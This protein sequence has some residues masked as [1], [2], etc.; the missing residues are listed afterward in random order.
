MHATYAV[1]WESGDKPVSSGRLEFGPHGL[2]LDGANGDGEA[3]R[4]TVAYEELAHVWIGRS[5]SERL[6]GLRTLV[7]ELTI[8]PPIRIAGVTGPGAMA[9]VAEQLEGH[10][11]RAAA[12]ADL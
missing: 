6:S 1:T 12:A 7:L 10:R 11:R 2:V 9:E 5:S 4:E 3:A 8:G